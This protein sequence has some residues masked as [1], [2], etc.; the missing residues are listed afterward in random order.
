M[1]DLKFSCFNDNPLSASKSLV[2]TTAQAESAL[3]EC[4]F[5]CVCVCVWLKTLRKMF[6]QCGTGATLYQLGIANIFK[7]QGFCKMFVKYRHYK[8]LSCIN[9]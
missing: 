5:V 1:V 8:K 6:C 2:E 4:Y 9:L 7:F 3:C